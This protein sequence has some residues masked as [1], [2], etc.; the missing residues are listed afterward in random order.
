MDKRVKQVLAGIGVLGAV[1]VAPIVPY[2]EKAVMWYEPYHNAE[3][4]YQRYADGSET[5]FSCDEYWNTALVKDYPQPARTRLRNVWTP[6]ETDAAIAVDNTSNSGT[7]TIGTSFSWS[8]TTSG[9]DRVLVVGVTDG[10]NNTVRVTGVT[11]NGESLSSSASVASG[12]LNASFYYLA[13]PDTGANTVQVSSAA[14][15][16]GI[17][18]AI[19]VTGAD[20]T[21]PIDDTDTSSGNGKSSS[22]SLTTT[23]TNSVLVDAL[24]V[25]YT[26][27]SGFTEGASQTL[28]A[29]A[30]N[31]TFGGEGGISYKTVSS[32]G[33]QSMSWTWGGFFGSNYAQ[34]AIAIKEGTGGGDPEPIYQSEFFF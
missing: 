32:S 11:Y 13:N 8:H 28:I 29:D 12:G 14:T 5:A 7:F 20:T 30:E 2:D 33:S 10:R 18:G 27:A 22:A 26:F 9:S 25:A 24:S 16:A 3:V 6:E 23:Q 15:L 31:V 21:D 1:S 34:V 19:S 4:C 17:A